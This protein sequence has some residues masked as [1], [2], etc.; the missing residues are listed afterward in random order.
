MKDRISLINVSQLRQKTKYIHF[1]WLLKL[2]V[3][4][5]FNYNNYLL[6]SKIYN[7][8]CFCLKYFLQKI[9]HFVY[10]KS[11]LLLKTIRVWQQIFIICVWKKP[12]NK[13]MNSRCFT[14]QPTMLLLKQLFCCNC[15]CS[16]IVHQSTTNEK[17]SKLR[18]I[19]EFLCAEH[20]KVSK[21]CQP[22]VERSEAMLP[23]AHVN[24][25]ANTFTIIII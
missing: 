20:T 6:L 24:Y 22:E 1:K 15:Q 4:F 11:F 3:R 16:E 18:H 2:L 9:K 19:M 21:N 12:Q 25:S 10:N 7:N 13:P 17:S 23:P 5:K 14:H 8:N